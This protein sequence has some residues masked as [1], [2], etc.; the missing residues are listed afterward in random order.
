MN[1]AAST[2]SAL[3]G[4]VLAF[5]HD[6]FEQGVDGAW[7]HFG[8]GMVVIEDGLIKA[9]GQA[10]EIA[11]SLPEGV[12]P[13]RYK[14]DLILAGFV[15]THVH[16]PQ[17]EVI[18]SYGA[19]LIE[20][21][22]KYTFPA[23]IKFSDFDIAKAAAGFFVQECFRN[24]VTTAAVY[25]T[26]HPQSVDA[27][28][29]TCAAHDLR[30]IAG[31]VLMDRNAPDGLKDTAQSAYDDSKALIERWH[32]KDRALYAITPRFAPTSTP[33]QL[34]AAA[35]LWREFDGTFVQTHVSENT[36]EIKWAAELFPDAKDYLGVYE[37]YGLLGPR[38]VLGH[39]IH[40]SARELD[41]IHDTGSAVAHC[42][43][44]NLFIGSGLFDMAGAKTRP[45]RLLTGLASDVAGGTSFSMFKTMAAA[46]EI[47]QLRG[48]SLHPVCAYYLAGPGAAKSLYLDDR[49]GN[50]EPGLEADLTVIDLS[51]TPLIAK[52]MN[53]AD[54]LIEAL[55]IQMI[56]A[57]DRAVRATYVNGK[58]TYLRKEM[59]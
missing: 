53:H 16:Y 13:E 52:R 27:F 3:R 2:V 41:V 8:D 11:S 4:Q 24:G 55:F 10:D 30:M 31:K 35:A 19:Q 25:C 22:E 29:E 28:F 43:T 56:L 44:S 42:P 34:E 47:A 40:L 59:E 50:L 58:R 5:R 6:P 9:V 12:E 36:D 23:E 39:G 49:I 21:L 15:D 26:V 20:W 57:D 7:Q 32:G 18:A 17:T 45:K 46:Y 14:D 33:E 37:M 51:S 54:D 48:Y 38:C 1:R